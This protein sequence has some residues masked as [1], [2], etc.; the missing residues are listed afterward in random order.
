MAHIEYYTCDRCGARIPCENMLLF[1]FV[2]HKNDLRE[3]YVHQLI[4][5]LAGALVAADRSTKEE[6]SEC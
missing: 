6:N 5:D 1:G 4:D 3:R 2:G